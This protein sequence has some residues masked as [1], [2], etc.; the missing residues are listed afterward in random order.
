[1]HV[2]RCKGLVIIQC[3]TIM[4]DC[5]EHQWG[6]REESTGPLGIDYL[7]L[8]LCYAPDW[9]Y[10]I[11]VLMLIW[12]TYLIK[13]LAGTASKYFSPTLGC[14]CTKMNMAY[15]IAGITLLAFGNG[16]PDFF[17]MVASVSRNVD[18]QVSAG[19]LLGGSV[20][21]CTVCNW[22]NSHHLPI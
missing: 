2:I 16:A 17:A 1:M 19:A 8:D 15:D 13:L 18:I 10:V 3:S 4:L 20:F 22:N 14:I 11:A 6:D 12:S 21:N 5:K 9:H 7:Y